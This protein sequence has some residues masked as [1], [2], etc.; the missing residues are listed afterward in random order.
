MYNSITI[1]NK[2]YSGQ[3][4]EG[5]VGISPDASFEPS[6]IRRLTIDPHLAGILK[7]DAT[8]AMPGQRPLDQKVVDE[9]KRRMTSG[10]WHT[11]M[12]DIVEIYKKNGD[13]QMREDMQDVQLAY[14]VNGN[15][16]INA[17]I[18]AMQAINA[19]VCIYQT[20]E[21]T[22]HLLFSQLDDHKPRKST[23]AL[24]P[25]ALTFGCRT[26]KR[27]EQKNI[28][29]AAILDLTAK[30]IHWASQD[31]FCKQPKAPKRDIALFYTRNEREFISWLISINHNPERPFYRDVEGTSENWL[32]RLGV[33]ASMYRTWKI[34]KSLA[35]TFWTGVVRPNAVDAGTPGALRSLLRSTT[36]TKEW[37]KRAQ[38]R[39]VKACE[40]HW[41]AFVAGGDIQVATLEE[42][43]ALPD[44]MLNVVVF[45]GSGVDGI[46]SSVDIPSENVHI[47][48]GKL[49]NRV[50]S[51]TERESEEEHHI[52]V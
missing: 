17:C 50:D 46:D 6:E 34:D 37:G 41:N 52:T 33:V 16:T 2:E 19:V 25:L 28:M 42:A 27:G 47:R 8:Q 36:S 11:S 31:A 49:D 44:E 40:A 32:W 20:T 23:T 12:I 13:P 51:S 30:A 45:A 24:E 48:E 15:H 18:E 35:N 1:G 5:E 4:G 26:G 10:L 22:M 3:L 38:G 9:Y 29:P 7:I 39:I 14:L 43:A 21:E